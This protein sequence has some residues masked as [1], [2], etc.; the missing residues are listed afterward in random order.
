MVSRCNASYFRSAH[1]KAN[2]FCQKIQCNA[3]N[4]VLE[5]ERKGVVCGK[6]VHGKICK[7]TG[8]IIS[9]ALLR[10]HQAQVLLHHRSSK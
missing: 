6:V 3:E 7:K 5:G 1:L 2:I 10:R 8:I 9:S 4:A